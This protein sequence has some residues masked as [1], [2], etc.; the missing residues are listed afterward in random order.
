MLITTPAGAS[1]IALSSSDIGVENTDII[2]IQIFRA[3]FA[4]TIFPQIINLVM[5]VVS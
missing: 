3:V 5:L 4:M 1:D 2:I